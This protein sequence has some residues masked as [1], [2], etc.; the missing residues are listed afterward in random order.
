MTAAGLRMKHLGWLSGSVF[1]LYLEDD[2]KQG[3]ETM[4]WGSGGTESHG[5]KV[6]DSQPKAA[7][8]S[9]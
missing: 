5:K 6:A 4:K 2:S 3:I 9:E 1:L 7:E 8:V